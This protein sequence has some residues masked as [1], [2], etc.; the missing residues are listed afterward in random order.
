M[1]GTHTHSALIS[2][3]RSVLALALAI[4]GF[5][6]LQTTLHA[7][8]LITISDA[9]PVAE[10]D[11]EIS[12]MTFGVSLSEAS[13]ETISVDYAT[14]PDS[15]T[16]SQD[17]TPVSGTL[18]FNPGQTWN[19]ITVNILGDVVNE[20]EEYVKIQL[21]NPVNAQIHIGEAIGAIVDTDD[22]KLSVASARVLETVGMAT[23]T[24]NINMALQFPVTVT[25]RTQQQ[26]AIEGVD[27]AAASGTVNFP[28]GTTS[29]TV[30]VQILND[31][32]QE[33]DE[34]F[35]VRMVSTSHPAF[36]L[37][38]YYA[39]ITIVDQQVPLFS[40]D[41][42]TVA[43]SDNGTDSTGTLTVTLSEALASSSTVQY[44]TEADTATANADFVPT[45]GTL[46]FPAGTTE[47]TITVT[48]KDDDQ[49]DPER[50]RVRLRNA[51][52]NTSILKDAGIVTITDNDTGTLTL[53]LQQSTVSEGSTAVGVV[54][55]NGTGDELE[56]L[57]TSSDETE[58]TV[59]AAM[60][61]RSGQ[62]SGTF[63][64]S[65]V[66]DE[67]LDGDNDVQITAEADG[68]GQ[69]NTVTIT[70]LN[71]DNT[72]NVVYSYQERG[73]VYTTS[74]T[75]RNGDGY[76]VINLNSNSATCMVKYTNGTS[77]VSTWT[78][79]GLLY[80]GNIGSGDYWFIT[81]GGIAPLQPAE[82]AASYDYKH[83]YGSLHRNINLGGRAV[84]DIAA[85]LTGATRSGVTSGTVNLGMGTTS[86]RI[87]LTE[88]RAYNQENTSLGNVLQ[89]LATKLGVTLPS[90]SPQEQLAPPAD[91]PAIAATDAT[92][93]YRS[94]ITG[95]RAGNNGVANITYNGWLVVDYATGQATLL[96][97]RN[98]T[99]EVVDLFSEAGW[100]YRLAVG[101]GYH[102]LGGDFTPDESQRRFVHIFGAD[103]S[104]ALN[105]GTQQTIPFALSGDWW[106]HE[107][108]PNGRGV[109][110]LATMRADIAVETLDLSEL[111]HDATVQWVLTNK[112]GSFSEGDVF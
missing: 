79:T 76:L 35:Y 102:I 112:L 92:V 82:T 109:F 73:N 64:I 6:L 106:A 5:L 49:K 20:V 103:T 81:N 99:Y 93:L 44:I 97:T 83:L 12:Q 74:G 14:V 25:W 88:T 9:D 37:T 16:P 8:I 96:A 60:R 10:G 105:T 52:S 53:S 85:A 47:R 56:V 3:D 22:V 108:A 32:Q 57:L 61:I 69:S 84:G 101:N 41:D 78:D 29:Q 28:A 77:S 50:F 91:N 1:T 95:I 23:T 63:A 62:S 4:V 30:S 98:T 55:R 107:V 40:I 80:T 19:S 7:Q 11:S 26:T 18:N 100:L 104:H 48:V 110:T 24:I 43:E 71:S 111:G 27:Y 54:T 70:V 51:S 72:R 46:Q 21:S 42:I 87:M 89:D 94:S 36:D 58:A 13:S 45:S 15:A 39:P 67:V 68:Y 38:D 2:S 31:L 34:I 65:G 90:G 66:Q 59:P 17:Y 75:P 86:A 33:G